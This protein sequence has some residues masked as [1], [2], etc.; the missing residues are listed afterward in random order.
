MHMC[1]ALQNCRLHV[2]VHLRFTRP[3]QTTNLGEPKPGSRG[4]QSGSGSGSSGAGADAGEQ[5]DERSQLRTGESP[6]PDE[7]GKYAAI[8]AFIGAFFGWASQFI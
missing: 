5:Q 2:N 4:R 7:T 6:L 1:G 3:G 8:G